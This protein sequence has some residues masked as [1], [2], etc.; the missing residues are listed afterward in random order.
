MSARTPVNRLKIAE[1][2]RKRGV[3]RLALFGSAAS[4]TFDPD[5]SDLDFLVEF[6][7]L[8]PAE[9]ADAY[10]GLLKD[11]EDLFG[12]PVD[13]LTPSSLQNPY[14]RQE[15]ERTQRELYAA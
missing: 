2:C 14:F 6:E 7:D 5:R 10:F 12:R 13:L 9:Y 11:L 3:Q 8:P 1:L 15:V 4:E